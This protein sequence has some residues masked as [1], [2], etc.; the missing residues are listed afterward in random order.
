MNKGVAEL[1]VYTE[2]TQSLYLDAYLLR[3]KRLQDYIDDQNKTKDKEYWAKQYYDILTSD[4]QM[5]SK[6]Y[7]YL[8]YK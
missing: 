8:C 6:Q 2:H 3:E 1:P 4:R 7:N 5:W